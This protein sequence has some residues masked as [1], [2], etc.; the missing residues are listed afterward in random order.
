[1]KPVEFSKFY[2]LLNEV[3]E[4]QADRKEELDLTLNEF[5]ASENSESP[6]HQ[7]GQI[8]IYRGIKELFE[9]AGTTD[10]ESIGRLEADDWDELT[11]KWK[12]ELPPHLANSM[13]SYAKKNA[14]SKL[15]SKKWGTPKRE[16]EKNIMGMARYVTEGI[17]DAIE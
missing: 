7:L 6:L 2:R 16:I 12:A 13:I 17:I 8:F 15:I 11:E 14:L 10:V 5:E 3:K 1:M 4:G 9:Y